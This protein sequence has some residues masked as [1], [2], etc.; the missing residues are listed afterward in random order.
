MSVGRTR[1]EDHWTGVET[2]PPPFLHNGR[3][4]RKLRDSTYSGEREAAMFGHLY[5]G[6]RARCY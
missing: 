4:A 5:K 6:P 2:S 3:F 1:S